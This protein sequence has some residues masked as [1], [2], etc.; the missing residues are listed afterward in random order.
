LREAGAFELVAWASS[1]DSFVRP[2]DADHELGSQ[3]RDLSTLRRV[4]KA[5]TA[6]MSLAFQERRWNDACQLLELLL[7]LSNAACHQPTVIDQLVGHACCALAIAE[8]RTC[9]AEQDIPAET[10]SRIMQILTDQPL[11]EASKALRGERVVLNRTIEYVYSPDR[12]KDG[13][14]TEE[15]L[16]LFLRSGEFVM[17]LRAAGEEQ[18]PHPDNEP[19]V[20]FASASE[21][22]K[23]AD[24]LWARLDA[25]DRLPCTERGAAAAMAGRGFEGLSDRY[26]LTRMVALACARFLQDSG[27]L[28]M[29]LDGLRIMLAL[30]AYS[31]QHRIRPESLHAL[32][33]HG[34]PEIPSDCATGLPFGYR[35]SDDRTTYTLYSVGADG[36]DDG[37]RINVHDND[38]ALQ[39]EGAGF[40]YLLNHPRERHIAADDLKN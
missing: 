17:L 3:I 25:A 21:M 8:T 19:R 1:S 18:G 15:I 26:V 30:E 6:A 22:S 28:Q 27:R 14:T 4:A 23:M 29:E 5:L 24:E 36:V 31:S 39:T 33:E 32:Q 12:K 35:V 7:V 10:A 38:R 37:G 13:P 11:P 2:I 9:V 20:E 40:D 34:L 16:K